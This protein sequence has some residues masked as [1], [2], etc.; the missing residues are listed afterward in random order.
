[1]P[2]TETETETEHVDVLIV[3]AGLSGVGAAC[4]LQA[5]CPGKT[6]AILE[7]RGSSG[8]TW[9]LF[10][11][12]GVR[13]DSDI[14]TLAYCFRPW[15]GTKAI[16]D[17]PSILRYIRE[18]ARQRG[19]DGRIRYHSRVVNAAWSSAEARWTI[20]VERA[21]AG[22]TEQMTCGFLYGNTGYYRY[23]AGY[24]PRLEGRE[25]FRGRIVHPQDWPDDL[26]W[27][28][29]RV[30]VIGSGATAVTLVPALAR[31]ARHVTM[32]QRSPSYIASVPGRDPVDDLV[33]RALPPG[34]AGRVVRWKNV[35]ITWL[36]FQLSRHAPTLMTRWLRGGVARQLPD[37]YDVDTHFTPAYRPW[38]QRLCFAP[39]GDLFQAISDGRVSVVSDRITS[40]T[41][42]GLLLESGEVLE[43]DVVIT[44]TGLTLL[45]LGGMTIVVDGRTVD[46]PETVAYKSLMLCE[47]PNLAFTFGY[48]NASWTLKS[49]LSARYVGRL[50][51]HMDEHGYSACTPMAPD[52]SSPTEPYL[53]LSSG[54]VRRSGG[55]FPKQG[56]TPPWRVRHNYPVD[57]LTFRY[58]RVDDGVRFSGPVEPPSHRLVGFARPTP[59]LRSR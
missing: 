9:D 57:V 38:D 12:P 44:A 36:I 22:T 50:L 3:G 34:A 45:I 43:A 31:Q 10:R 46:I 47:V 56:T 32:L 20:T 48:T 49:D 2:R 1:M 42:T 17:G 19:I 8:G 7:A 23:D 53:D 37:G 59:P 55:A 13:S 29:E 24:T 28:D 14:F 11:Y 54:Y 58:G 15:E 26:D 27:T 25:R 5:E 4:H 18:T 40:F 51:K 21:D 16:V 6:F 30:V 33:R 39:D 52:P 35:V 41:E